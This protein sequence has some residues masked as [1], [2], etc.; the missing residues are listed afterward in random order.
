MTTK[1]LD[2]KYVAATYK[3][4]PVEIALPAGPVVLTL[5]ARED[6]AKIDRLFLTAEGN[7]RLR[8]RNGMEVT[9]VLTSE[10]R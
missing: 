3:R 5:H 6:G 9:E 2:A 10:V 4:F 8:L 1:E 7:V